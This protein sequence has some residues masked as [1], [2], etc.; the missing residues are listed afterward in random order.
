MRYRKPD[1]LSAAIAPVFNPI[2]LATPH[3]LA[4]LQ[5][6][7]LRQQIGYLARN[8][9]LYQNRFTDAGINPGDIQTIEDLRQIPFTTKQDLRDS[10]A[11]S[12]PLGEHL[13][14][15]LEAIVQIQASSGTTGSPSY[16]GLTEQDV[17][18]W[19]EMTARA[20]FACGMRPNDLVLHTFALG[21]GFVGGI[22]MFQAV[23]HLG[24]MDIPIGADGGADRLLIAARDLRPRCAIGTPNFLLYLAELAKD[25]TGV[26][27]QELGIKRLIVGGEPGGGIP[28]I[29]E[30]L[31][32][33]WNATCCEVLGGT[34][35]G[36]TYW[37]ESDSQTGMHMVGPDHVLAE[38]IDPETEAPLPFEEGVAGE[39]VYSA[40]TRQASPVLRFRSGDH[41]VVTSTSGADGRPGPTIRCVGRTDDMLIVRGVNLF[42]SSVQEIVAAIP[43]TNG[44]MRVV[45]DFEGHST[46]GNLKVLVERGATQNAAADTTVAAAVETRIRNALAVKAEVTIVP[47]DFFLKPGALKVALTL[48]EMPTL[49]GDTK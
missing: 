39:L 4:A 25:V 17:L 8:S 44:I 43:E 46:Q 21:K 7:R 45:A 27:A 38:L 22:P 49:F 30:A 18:S 29:R 11:R 48:R 9:V 12:T 13:A 20:L 24:A 23:Q 32:A 36:C 10:L 14:A 26:A 19:Q 37:A 5:E 3:D 34:D 1:I 47:T 41:I 33:A 16:V 40:L 28:A 6:T 15:P 42:P 35:L 2:E 31:E